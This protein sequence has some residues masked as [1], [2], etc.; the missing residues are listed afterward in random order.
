[1]KV[2]QTYLR[3]SYTFCHEQFVYTG[4]MTCQHAKWYP[5]STAYLQ[6]DIV[7]VM[8]TETQTQYS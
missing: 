8:L 5:Y 3:R 2:V 4:L 6:E 1:M 7:L